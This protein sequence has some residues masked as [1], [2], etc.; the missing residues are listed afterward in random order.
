MEQTRRA[1]LA[2]AVCTGAGLAAASLGAAP[3]GLGRSGQTARLGQ[4]PG[5]ADPLTEFA[6][7]RARLGQS[8]TLSADGASYGA[9][10]AEVLP[11]GT[12]GAHLAAASMRSRVWP[13]QPFSVR[14][15]LDSPSAPAADTLFDLSEPIGSLRQL[16]VHPATSLSNKAMVV[17]FF[18]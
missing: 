7:W 10:I 6:H 16:L 11:S 12:P 18:G 15:E 4:Q 1:I 8:M 13:R 9:R 14:L 17:A 5:P 3:A 2:G